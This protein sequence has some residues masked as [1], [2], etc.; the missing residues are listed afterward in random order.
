MRTIRSILWIGPGSGLAESDVLDT[1]TLDVTWVADL[2]EALRLPP[3]GF[4]AEVVD[5]L[6]G[7]ALGGAVR[8]LVAGP[9]GSP[10]I[11]RVAEPD[12][13]LEASLRAAGAAD[14]L[15]ATCGIDALQ[16]RIDALSAERLF[17]TAV[18]TGEPLLP[19]VVGVS[20]AMRALC[21]L[22]SRASDSSAT[23]LLSGETGVGKEVIARALHESGAR[24]GRQFVA[25]NCA[26]F[27]DSLLESELFGHVPRRLHGCAAATRP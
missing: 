11:A 8:R 3:A 2:D 13:A 16:D 6:S 25:V 27:P 19:G 10:V 23:V 4:D 9:R 24:A 17:R 22:V 26:A 7:D 15:P 12:A 18:D 20:S 1:P 5:G 14:V 21:A